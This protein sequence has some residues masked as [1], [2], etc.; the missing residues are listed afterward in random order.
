MASLHGSRLISGVHLPN[1][2]LG[3]PDQLVLNLCAAFSAWRILLSGYHSDFLRMLN[4][5]DDFV[6]P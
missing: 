1:L 6:D 4:V 5:I 2:V 3:R